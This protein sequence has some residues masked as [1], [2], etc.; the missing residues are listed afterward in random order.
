MAIYDGNWRSYCMYVI[1]SVESSA[2]YG[3]IE[4]SAKQGIGIMQWTNERSWQLLNLLVTDFPEM[5]SYFPILYSSISPDSQQWGTKYFADQECNEI[6][7]ALVTEQGVA[8]Q[9]KLWNQDCEQSYIPLVRDQCPITNPW[10]AIFALSVYHQAPNAF[11]DIFNAC[12]DTDYITWYNTTLNNWVVGQYTNRQNTVKALLDEWDGES[13]KEGFGTTDATI[14]NGGNIDPNNGNTDNIVVTTESD[15]TINSIEMYK[16]QLILNIVINSEN[17]KMLFYKA[18]NN[19][20]YPSVRNKTVAGES[21]TTPVPNTPPVTS[22]TGNADIQWMVD[23]IQE[24]DGTLY[25]SQVMTLRTNIEGGYCDC[26]GLVWWLYQQRGYNIGTWTGAQIYDGI[27]VDQG[28]Y[29]ALPDLSVMKAGD[30]CI[31]DHGETNFGSLGHVEMYLG[32]GVMM[33]HSSVPWYGPTKKN[34]HEYAQN[35][36]HYMIRRIILE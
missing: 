35:E 15:I 27:E 26:S 11:Y 33:G 3:C 10:T 21:Q 36:N 12:G 4:M 6:S 18:S 9:D 31:F 17:S 34:V 7:A 2:D 28:D 19:L 29:G 8:T 32:D 20:W 16:K 14:L 25:Y 1:S 23:K 24:L 13:A 5:E 22:E 30:L